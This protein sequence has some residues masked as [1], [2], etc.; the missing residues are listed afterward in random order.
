MTWSILA[1]DADGRFGV[2]IAS[3]FFAVGALCVAHAARRRRAVDA[4]ADE[5][6]VRPGRPRRCSPRAAPPP[7]SLRALTAADAG[8]DQ[9]QL[10]VLRRARP[11]RRAHRR[12]PASTGAAT[13]LATTSAS[14]A[15]CWPVRR[16]SRRP[17][18]AYATTARPAA[19]RAPARRDGGRRGRRRRQARQ[20]GRGAAHPR[21]RGLPAA[22]PAGR[23]PR[24]AD[25]RT[26]AAVRRSACERFQPFVACLPG[27][28]RPGRR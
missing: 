11:R 23:R 27:R 1:R 10:H 20:A 28:A 7:T 15:T 26:A 5:S 14:P 25:R 4:G 3:R 2:A 12:A 21:R 6:A 24:R 13:S 19:G 17:P 8:R 16:C 18:Q 9:R 22:R